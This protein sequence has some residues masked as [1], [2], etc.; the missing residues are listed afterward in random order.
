MKK[1]TTLILLLFTN[2]FA[3]AQN[4]CL[5]AVTITPGL[6]VVTAVNGTKFQIQFVQQMALEQL[7][8]NGIFIRQRKLTPLL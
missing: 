8:E 3:F 2:Y 5:T 6:H 7:Q 1:T 4:T